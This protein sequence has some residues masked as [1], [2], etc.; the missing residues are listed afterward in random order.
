MLQQTDLLQT[1]YMAVAAKSRMLDR[2]VKTGE[3]DGGKV[4][5]RLV[6]RTEAQRLRIRVI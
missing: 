5:G 4:K 3:S 6:E 1:I 2:Q